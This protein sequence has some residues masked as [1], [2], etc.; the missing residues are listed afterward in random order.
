MIAC[1]NGAAAARL[2]LA[3]SRLRFAAADATYDRLR[4]PRL[5]A[6]QRLGLGLASLVGPATHR[7]VVSARKVTPPGRTQGCN[8]ALPRRVRGFVQGYAQELAAACS[9]R[10]LRI[11]KQQLSALPLQSMAES[12]AEGDRL[13][14]ESLQSEDFREGV[15]HFVEKRAP[16]FSGR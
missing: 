5:I 8:S 10:S 12:F 11:I 15:A 2:V 3:S 4:A 6:E 7:P 14:H 13:M 9:P 16:R 1:V